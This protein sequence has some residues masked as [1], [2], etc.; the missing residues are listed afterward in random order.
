M[1][2]TANAAGGKPATS[3]AQAT[4][5]KVNPLW[6][7]YACA[8]LVAAV[9]LGNVLRWTFLDRSDPYHCSA[10]LSTGKWLDPGK[11]T[12]WQ[13][14]GCF[15]L[16]LP[17]PS[18]Q[19]CLASPT[20]NTPSSSH[21][22]KR[23]V[24]FV[25]DSTV[26]QLYFS[27]TR[28]VGKASK[29]WENDGEKHTDR[30]LS[31]TDPK[32]GPSLDLEFW[33]DPYL[34][35][36]RTAELLTGSYRAPASL[37]VMGSGL[38]YLRNP[39]SGGLASWGG[40]VHDTFESLK[41]HQ[42]SPKTALLNPWDDMLL[43]SGVI[44]PGLLPAIETS[45]SDFNRIVDSRSLVPRARISPTSRNDFSIADAVVFL[46]IPNP[47]HAKLSA[48]RAETIM[49]TDVEAMNADLYARLTHANPPPVIIP[50]VLNN[51]L[52]DEE[53]DDGLHFSDKIMNK[54]AE[55]LLSWR[56]N[57]VMRKEGATGTCCK[58]YDWVTP[59]QGLILFLMVVWAPVGL[60]IAPRLPTS[61]PIHNFIPSPSIA[62]AFSTFGLAMGYLF[63]AD[64][65]TVF[66]KEQKDYDSA[67]FGGLT[68]VALLVGLATMR[69]GG[70][71]LGFL[72]RD[73]TDEWKGWMQIAILIYHFFG[74]SK[75]SG[76]YNP[77]RVL[78]ASYLF[79]TG[80]G[81]FF[82]YYKKADFGFQ[83]V[84]MVL[85]RLNLLSVVL[86]Y[87]MNTDYAFYY[88]APL[89]SWWYI[90]IYFTMALG[91]KYN[92]RPAFLL[93]KLFACAALHT[94]FMHYTFLMSSIFKVLNAVFR[95]QWSAKEWSFRVTLDLYIVW[96][97]MFCAYAYIKFKEYKI[98]DRPSFPL[99]RNVTLGASALGMIWYFWF[100]LHLLNK[101]VYNEYHA[102]V[103]VV[104][105]MSFVFLRNA[106]PL[107]RSCSSKLFCF[108]G[109]CSLETFILQ[110]HGWL[111]SDTKSILLVIP[112]TRWRPV[113]LVIS[114]ICFV[115]LSYRV[116][117]ATGEITE[118][119]V[120]KGKKS[121]PLPATAGAG[122]A[123]EPAPVA[124][125]TA[126][127]VQAVV[128]G[129]KDGAE[130]GVPES[131][132]L[133]NQANKDLN[134]LGVPEGAD[135]ERRESWPVWMAA[136]AASFSGRTAEGYAGTDTRW[137]DQTVL[138]VLRNINSLAQK[139]N[140]VKLG[141]VL[142]GLWFLNWIY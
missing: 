123:S 76:I 23:S 121:L 109:Q 46:P 34:N 7:T 116:S 6:Y 122:G 48:S 18:L 103:C 107:L 66:L 36:S 26:R 86:P 139:H 100:Q 58:R 94:V 92:E 105:I 31:V 79:M 71:D 113:N 119:I 137:K 35:G 124:T 44:L 67:I 41:E 99:M 138:N 102:V 111:G 112:A 24:L 50:S 19:R 73:I 84:A 128:E 3:R 90:I 82:Y 69:N 70:K 120:G 47:V 104:P 127:A 141:L 1:P 59:V 101:F 63:L 2:G 28:T 80:Y 93:G 68:L 9:V 85:V 87:T 97:G 22:D 32:G 60:L 72:N 39:T 95:I 38:W 43:G 42:G 74:A 142:V 25:G 78:V 30:V 45:S 13:P 11:W 110:F 117:G 16:P 136:T 75:I 21:P 57:D 131:I 27:L 12:N 88:F 49:H 20:S 61:S 8:T 135:M 96:C 106:S 118:Y 114:T 29:A 10:L 51:L 37:L 89:T 64:R 54:Q 77:I 133:M 65:T 129:P 83:R 14:E 140:S 108:I 125:T 132:P 91:A 33:W 130:G 98:A 17:A 15:Q 53:T 134:G 4:S 62:A 115:W 81:H 56:C 52:V 5:S 126:A 40:M 55:L